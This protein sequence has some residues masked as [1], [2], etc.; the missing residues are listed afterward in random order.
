MK[1]RPFIVDHSTGYKFSD[2][3]TVLYYDA[4]WYKSQGKPTG[5]KP[6]YQYGTY[7]LDGS[8]LTTKISGQ[9]DEI[10]GVISNDMIVINGE[11]CEAVTESYA[12]DYENEA[13]LY[14]EEAVKS[15]VDEWN[16]KHANACLLG[17][18]QRGSL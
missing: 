7:S 2:D 8:A 1:N 17:M 4:K 13:E 11:E 12:Y 10:T 15:Y 6:E 18:V 16:G 5:C 3:G 9:N 14:S